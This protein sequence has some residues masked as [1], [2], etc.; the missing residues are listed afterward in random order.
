[1]KS[2]LHCAEVGI[3]IGSGSWRGWSN[4]QKTIGCRLN[5]CLHSL[6][7]L[8]PPQNPSFC[9]LT[10]PESSLSCCLRRNSEKSPTGWRSTNTSSS[11][12]QWACILRISSMVTSSTGMSMSDC[13][14]WLNC[15]AGDVSATTTG[16]RVSRGLV[17]KP[18]ITFTDRR[19]YYSPREVAKLREIMEGSKR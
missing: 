4:W 6:V 2:R 12:R 9:Q 10:L 5:S 18:T 19:R 16:Y 1:M 11:S 8:L 15:A 7:R 14:S 17:P 3:L 13:G